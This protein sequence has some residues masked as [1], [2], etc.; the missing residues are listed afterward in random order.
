[1][2]R[3]RNPEGPI[4][5]GRKKSPKS[6]KKVQ[7]HTMLQALAVRVTER[8]QGRGGVFCRG[9]VASILIVHRTDSPVGLLPYG[10][11][12]RLPIACS[13]NGSREAEA[14]I[15]IRQAEIVKMGL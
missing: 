5:L 12:N 7:T 6:G 9:N 11:L 8:K 3:P 15:A 4:S 10:P 13:S 2:K 14:M 1:M